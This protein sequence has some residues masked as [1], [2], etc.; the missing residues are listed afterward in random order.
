MIK[1][2]AAA[3]WISAATIG[4]VYYSF[5]SSAPKAEGEQAQPM[6]GGLD[7]VKTE[8]ISVPVV[9]DSAVTGYFLT[10]LVYTVDPAVMGK[11]SVPAESMIV[12]QVYSYLFGS[13]EIDFSQTTGLDLDAFRGHIR[14]AINKRVGEQ[15]VYEVLV[16]QIE[17][18]TKD[19]I[20]DNALRR[21]AV[22]M[23]TPKFVGGEAGAKPA[24]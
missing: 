20:R 5:Q 7:Y 6:L 9:K 13:P 1:F 17:Y 18:L 10:K 19:E 11:L 12:D 16:E 3:I 23:K 4:A 21:R 15:L 22:D 14:D 2:I 24:H 8:M